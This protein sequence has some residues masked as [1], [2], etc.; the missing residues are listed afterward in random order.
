MH[1]SQNKPDGK[2]QRACTIDSHLEIKRSPTMFGLLTTPCG[3]ED[4]RPGIGVVL[5]VGLCRHCGEPISRKLVGDRL[6][7]FCLATGG[8]Q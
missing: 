3:Y 4:H 6:L 8:A 2:P 5:E 7:A 1:L